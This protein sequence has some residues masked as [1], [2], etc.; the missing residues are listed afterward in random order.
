MSDISPAP[1]SLDHVPDDYMPSIRDGENEVLVYLDRVNA[2]EADLRAMA[3]APDLLAQLVAVMAALRVMLQGEGPVVRAM[4][5]RDY[6]VPSERAIAKA[7]GK[8][9]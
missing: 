1:W 7:R 8:Y 3:A 4:V 2:T 6:L 9:D 5:E